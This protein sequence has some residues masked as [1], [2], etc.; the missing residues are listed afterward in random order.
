[1]HGIKNICN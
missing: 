1:M